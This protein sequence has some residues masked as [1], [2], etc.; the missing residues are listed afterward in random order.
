MKMLD[1]VLACNAL[2]FSSLNIDADE[3]I[4]F[5]A[6]GGIFVVIVLSIIARTIRRIAIGR[7]T[8]TSRQEIAAYI[9]EGSM[10]AEEGER[11]LNAGRPHWER[12]RC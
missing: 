12:W 6:M 10:S 5:V 11:L 3:I 9:A 7:A 4:P 8:E 2:D 1:T